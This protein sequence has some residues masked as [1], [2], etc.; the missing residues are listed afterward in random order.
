MYQ[1]AKQKKS[2]QNS[3]IIP[4]LPPQLPTLYEE[5]SFT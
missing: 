5:N 3:E 4:T 2:I 1:Q